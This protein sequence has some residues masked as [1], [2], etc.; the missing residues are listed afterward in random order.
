[1]TDPSSSLEHAAYYFDA[2]SGM[3]LPPLSIDGGFPAVDLV[4]PVCE[5][6]DRTRNFMYSLQSCTRYPF[7]LILADSGP[8][9]IPPSLIDVFEDAQIVR[10]PENLG[11]ASGCNVGFASG[12]HALAAV[13]R[14]DL[15]LT[16]GWLGRLARKM[17]ED[18][19]I[20]AVAPSTSHGEE[21]QAIHIG[22]FTDEKEMQ[23]RA[24][25]FTTRYP[26]IVEDVSRVTG[27]CLLVRR[28]VLNETGFLDER[29][30]SGD[31]ETSDL[32]LRIKNLG[33][34]V[35]VARDVFVHQISG[36][37]LHGPDKDTRKQAYHAQ[38]L[39]REKW[40]SDGWVRGRFLE[41]N[42]DLPGALHAYISS[43][44]AGCSNPDPLLRIG[45]ILLE[46]GR[47]K[48]AARAFRQY[49]HACPDST[50]GRVGFGQALCLSDRSRDGLVHL[51]AV[52]R[53][54][55]LSDRN[56]RKLE[57]SIGTFS[58]SPRRRPLKSLEAGESQGLIG[59]Q[60][61][62]RK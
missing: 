37:P 33:L 16:P 43:L 54:G 9:P 44:K 21:E 23:A 14:N 57:K 35:V 62:A 53:S 36:Q 4:M 8:D 6:L 51:R 38:A 56:R 24:A 46:L 5:S 3:T 12:K 47:F 26:G 34:R 32:C 11:Y 25:D 7:K 22:S 58:S 40:K 27:G 41:K 39:F 48:P 42:N 15:M 18:P 30:N 50:A 10:C 29:F 49:L 1:M 28:D 20:A 55:C 61:H 13:T 45:F 52:L 60:Y 2:P 31:L 59:V 19:S 17:L